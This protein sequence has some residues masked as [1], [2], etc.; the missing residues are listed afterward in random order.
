MRTFSDGLEIG[1]RN[2]P[3]NVYTRIH[4]LSNGCDHRGFR[5]EFVLDEIKCKLDQ[6][7]QRVLVFIPSYNKYVFE[8]GES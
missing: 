2:A 8:W 6:I 3:I 5:R 4:S 7:R 1:L